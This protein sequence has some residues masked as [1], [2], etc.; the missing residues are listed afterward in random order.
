[1]VVITQENMIL[2]N[3]PFI[4]KR[5]LAAK[6]MA[7]WGHGVSPRSQSTDSAGERWRSI[8][9]KKADWWFAYTTKSVDALKLVGFPEERITNVNNAIDNA[10]FEQDMNNV[11]EAMLASI[12]AQ[13]KLDQ[14]SVVGLYCGALYEEKRLDLLVAAAD[15]IHQCNPDFRLVVIGAGAKAE[16]IQE[17]FRTREWATAVGLKSGV[18]KAAYFK[19]AHVI[20]NPG[21][22]GL[23]ALDALCVG[24]PIIT[25]GGDTHH[26]PEVAMLESGLTGYFPEPTP[27]AYAQTV[28]DLLADKQR[29]IK[30][31]EAALKAAKQYTIEN[32]VQCFADG[33]EACLYHPIK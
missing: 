31:C 27:Q 26:S 13:C 8:W 21:L 3:Y 17:A 12:R 32:M 5:R 22:I 29:Y 20:L 15:L 6:R 4:F 28:I 14:R 25:T 18:E 16:F 19:L 30:S 9:A 24:L 10:A 23:I 7:F 11:T 33:V 2:S 1:L